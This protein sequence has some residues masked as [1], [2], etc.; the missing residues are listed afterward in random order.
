MKSPFD[1]VYGNRS[2][3]IGGQTLGRDCLHCES[4]GLPP[5]NILRCSRRCCAL[6]H[7][8]MWSRSLSR[9]PSLKQPPIQFAS[10]PYY[11]IHCIAALPLLN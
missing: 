7:K 10:T 9:P 11:S 2:K 6:D 5:H 8:D 3:P 4:A 1:G